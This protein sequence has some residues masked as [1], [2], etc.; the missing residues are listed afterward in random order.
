MDSKPYN[1]LYQY[2][3]NNVYCIL[4][5]RSYTLLF[6][7]RKMGRFLCLVLLLV[8][9]CSPVS[10][11]PSSCNC[12]DFIITCSEDVSISLPQTVSA[13]RVSG[14]PTPG[15]SLFINVS[16]FENFPHVRYLEIQQLTVAQINTY[17]FSPLTRLETLI[18]ENVS[19]SNAVI[20]H[21]AFAGLQAKTLS[22]KN[23]RLHVVY[24]QIFADCENIED[25]DLSGN[26]I[27]FIEDKAFANLPKL[28]KLN[29][30]NNYLITTTP[31]WFGSAFYNE[32]DLQL[33]L[34]GNNLSCD[35]QYRGTMYKENQWFI[36][37]AAA[38][39]WTCDWNRL[40]PSCEAPHFL[41]V[42]KEIDIMEYSSLT[43]PCD[44]D[45]FP[46][47]TVKWFLP[48]SIQSF[49]STGSYLNVKNG[50][51]N[52]TS[53][54]VH[55]SGTY[56]CMATNS[57]GSAVGLYQI[58]V[59]LKPIPI[60]MVS[61]AF[62]LQI[63]KTNPM[64]PIMVWSVII[65]VVTVLSVVFICLMRQAVEC[66]RYSATLDDDC[67]KFVDAPSIM[68]LPEN[69]P[70]FSDIKGG[71]DLKIIQGQGQWPTFEKQYGSFKV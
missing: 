9:Q 14:G 8:V 4:Y 63:R 49:N 30:A 53:A 62:K 55:F 43:V 66:Y 64:E 44:A 12:T 54:N 56:A 27:G 40:V 69:P 46:K 16:T 20:H 60:T 61:Y 32:T 35:C 2:S 6:V 23:N 34:L 15:N 26:Q 13:D 50:K 51:L 19:L 71:A 41:P 39:N 29:V 7:C 70:P 22:L 36:Q 28:R 24:Q 42:Y 1:C 48:N 47:P 45:G 65:I 21:D 57:E 33:N 25:I 10:M 11:C 68:S 17:A 38:N 37:A 31:Y 58:K 3:A 59:T 52:I 67:E 5:M 18:L